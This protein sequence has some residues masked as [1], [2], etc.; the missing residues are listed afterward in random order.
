MQL[1]DISRLQRLYNALYIFTWT[2]R[3]ALNAILD[4]NKTEVR[5]TVLMQ[6]STQRVNVTDWFLLRDL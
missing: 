6:R 2:V 4:K 5:K 1:E 3:K